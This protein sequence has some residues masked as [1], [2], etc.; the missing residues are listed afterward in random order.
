A[1]ETLVEVTVNGKPQQMTWAE[2]RKGVMMHAAFTQKTQALA[3]EKQQLAALREQAQSEM[4][5]AQQR[6]QQVMQILQDPAKL[7]AV[8]LALQS[9]QAQQGQPQYA[10]PQPPLDPAA[11]Q[12]QILNSVVP[13]VMQT[14]QAKQQEAAIESDV[15]TFT[16]G[17]IAD[18]PILS[19]FPGFTDK[20]YE[21]VAKMG[22]TNTTEAKDYIRAYI[23]DA[24][25]KL[26]TALGTTQK[27][28]AVAK[29]KAQSAT[30]PG[31]SVVH[32]S[33][34]KYT[35]LSDMQP[36]MEAFLD[37]LT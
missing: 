29:A 22:P 7:S 26:Q 11:F 36:D 21:E 6:S 24:R 25:A 19:I 4:L 28:A 34:K 8:Y 16:S 32:P 12:Q 18:D 15:T 23:D 5:A 9:Q 3:T 30:I 33:A 20:V 35:K 27:T 13:Q 37:S 1:D 14:I 17:L 2:A 31:G 10:V